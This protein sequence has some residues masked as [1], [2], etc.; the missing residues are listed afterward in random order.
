MKCNTFLI[1]YN[2]TTNYLRKAL[3]FMR[4]FS[5][6]SYHERHQI[7]TGLCQQ[8]SK[9]VI[10]KKLNRPTSAVTR[11]VTRNSDQYGY[12]YP[13]AAQEATEERKNK[14]APKIDRN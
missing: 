14:N 5:Q 13:K 1:E 6:L 8:L 4:R 12:F 3:H 7:Y 2:L 10:A 11:E 9:R